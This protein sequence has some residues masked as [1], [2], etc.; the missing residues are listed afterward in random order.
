MLKNTILKSSSREL[1]GINIQQTIEGE[2]LSISDLKEAYL[3]ARIQNGWKHRKI[4]DIA[5]SQIFQER[6]FYTL[7]SAKMI[8][9]GFPD[10]MKNI[11][12]K[13]FFKYMKEIGVY[14][15]TGARENKT[16][17]AN[18]YLFVAFALELNPEIYGKVI[19]W[20]TDGLL[21]ERLEACRNY[22][23]MN[24]QVKNLLNLTKDE[25]LPY[26]EIAIAINKK[27]FG[28]HMLGIRNIATKEQLTKVLDIEKSITA[29][30][31]AKLVTDQNQ[32]K[33][34]INNY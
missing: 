8:N 26:Q 33:Q 32:I 7:L 16:S 30:V 2:L 17:W 27:V 1:F 31:K 25:Y 34:F 23:E 12:L 22:K 21:F 4:E 15:T 19:C 11:E 28:A 29:I 6:V 5:E 13:G 9:S 20:L 3:R 24:D 18:P 14:K 10:F